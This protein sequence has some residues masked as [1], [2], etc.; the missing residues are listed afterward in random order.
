MKMSCHWRN[1]WPTLRWGALTL[2]ML[3]P[4]W[5]LHTWLPS[6]PRWVRP[7]T[8]KDV[9]FA[10]DSTRVLVSA[11]RGPVVQIWD[12]ESGNVQAS[13]GEWARL[14]GPEAV[15]PDF[16]WWAGAVARKG[17]DDDTP[18][19]YMIDLA[20]GQERQ[21]AIVLERGEEVAA[22]GL[23]FAP[24]GGVFG[25]QTWFPERPLD[26][27]IRGH[28]FFYGA[29][30]GKPRGQWQ[31]SQIRSGF[32]ADG[33]YYV[34]GY[35]EDE[36]C[37][38]G[39]WDVAAGEPLPSLPAGGLRHNRSPAGA[40]V[41]C[42]VQAADNRC[43]VWL[44]DLQSGQRLMLGGDRPA[45]MPWFSHDGQ[46]VVLVPSSGQEPVEVWEVNPVR[47]RGELAVGVGGPT[48]APDCRHMF[49]HSKG[50][51]GTPYLVVA[52]LE[53]FQQLWDLPW[54]GDMR[55]TAYFTADSSA[56]AVT[57]FTA[58]RF[59]IFETRNGALR[60]A[61]SPFGWSPAGWSEWGSGAGIGGPHM[62]VCA[63]P[64][65][66]D[67][68][69]AAPA[70]PVWWQTLLESLL[71]PGD[72]PSPLYT[73]AVIDTRDGRVAF[74]MQDRTL[75]ADIG[76]GEFARL[77][78]DG[79]SL[80]TVHTR[81]DSHEMRCYDVPERKPWVW[82]IGIP[83]AVGTLLASLRACWR[84]LLRRPAATSPA[85]APEGATP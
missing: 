24:N 70:G 10:P 56:L 82:I 54:P 8:S 38:L 55:H 45:C 57:D 18:R 14:V 27:R 74:R 34:G 73:V 22:R 72:E 62:L 36:A 71:G 85:P 19:L 68:P 35:L 30:T 25:L 43:V 60:A 31:R 59:E 7:W 48:F 81:G 20:S 58:A 13:Y 6:T 75:S 42:A 23:T 28:T 69:A 33:R 52:D 53:T 77:S 39:V 26:E 16:R 78:P 61:A 67:R 21:G 49:L 47:K 44:W 3:G 64:K 50:A 29:S 76:L 12:V 41:A 5:A 84:R 15:S 4:G 17:E 66:D 32:T 65:N 2:A 40:H 11:F 63:T 37:H 1:P 9:V 79:H 83:L 46:L 51:D 80:L